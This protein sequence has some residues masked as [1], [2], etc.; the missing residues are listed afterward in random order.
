MVMVMGSSGSATKASGTWHQ[1]LCIL[2]SSLTHSYLALREHLLC[3]DILHAM[4]YL[5]AITDALN[6]WVRR[7]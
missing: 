5:S 7:H 3:E 6:V 1:D 4:K 2:Q